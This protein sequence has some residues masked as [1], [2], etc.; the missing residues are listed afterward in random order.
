MS[1]R[2]T[3]SHTF[4]WAI[5]LLARAANAEDVPWDSASSPKTF[6][7]NVATDSA[8]PHYVRFLLE[9]AGVVGF[10]VGW[11][12]THMDFSGE[13]VELGWD[14]N[15]WRLKLTTFPHFDT[16]GFYT[17][18]VAHGIAGTL[19]YQ[20]AR[21]NGFGV[22]G[23]T[24]VAFA[25][26][27]FWEYVV[28]YR[29]RP[30]LNDIIINTSLGLSVGEPLVRIARALRK[31]KPTPARWA[32]AVAFSPFDALN[33]GLDRRL[34][35]SPEPVP[36]LDARLSLGGRIAAMPNE[37]GRGELVA[38]M[39][40]ELADEQGHGRPGEISSG[41]HAGARTGVEASVSVLA[42]GDNAGIVGAHAATRTSLFG[43][44]DQEIADAPNGERGW[45]RFLGVGTAFDFDIRQLGQDW[46]KLAILHALGPQLFF[47]AYFGPAV[48]RWQLLGYGDFA[49]VQALVFGPVPPFTFSMPPTSTLRSKGY[50]FGYGATV[51]SRLRLELR[52]WSAAIALRGHQNLVD[53]RPR[54][55]RDGRRGGPARCAGPT[56]LRPPRARR[57]VRSKWLGS[58]AHR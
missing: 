58:G 39:S 2:S 30:S 26:T 13:D 55:H 51:E 16:N 22:G 56:R 32:L 57:T 3:V 53:R 1:P 6:E 14:W 29:E 35:L 49:M 27:L 40:F 5:L 10:Q 4:V 17:N 37:S 47:D 24:L 8:R 20:A 33:G 36:W 21:A 7:V 44:Y 46:D 15:S 54:P 19:E 41:T 48:L 12:W 23:S 11:Y 18:S 43:R 45:G 28:E 9:E 34:L 31:G 52:G 42:G 38:G 25:G 50:Y